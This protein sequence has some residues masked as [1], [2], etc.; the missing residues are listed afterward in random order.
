MIIARHKLLCVNNGLT[1]P[2]VV[3]VGECTVCVV[4]VCVCVCVCTSIVT[5]ASSAYPSLSCLFIEHELQSTGSP[6]DMVMY[7]HLHVPAYTY[8]QGIGH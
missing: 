3:V 2:N 5:V 6:C 7:L 1:P 4:C 8:P